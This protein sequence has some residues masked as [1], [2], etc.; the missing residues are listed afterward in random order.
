VKISRATRGRLRRTTV[1]LALIATLAPAVSARADTTYPFQNP[2]LSL[3]ARVDDLLGRLT[4]DEKISLLH[5]YEPA[6]PRL[7]IKAF[8]AGT[9]A[10]HGYAWTSDAAGN[11]IYANG[12]VF[13]QAVGLASTWDPA[14]IKQVGNVVGTEARA[15]NST[16]DANQLWGLNVWAPVVNLLRDPRWGR[17]EEGY[18]EDPALTTAI[19]SAYGKGLE[20]DN[21]KYLLTA[22]TL[23]HYLAYNNEV[24]RGTSD[25]QVTD[26][27]LKDYDQKPFQGTLSNEAATG[28]MSSYNRVNGRPD[29]VNP[30]LG[31]L[32]RSWSKNP[33]F[34]V[35]DA[36]SAQ[37]LAD[38]GD[39]AT[40]YNHYYNGYTEGDAA[41]IKAGI[42]SFTQ[43]NG[44][45]SKTTIPAI[46]DALAKGLLTTGDIDKAVKDVLALRI[47]LGEFDPDGGPYAKID[48][49]AINTTAS[50]ALNRKTAAE[51][52]VL[53]K[54]QG[55]Q[56]P[57]AKSTKSVAVV[58]PL[59]NVLYQD[60]YSG[61][62]PYSVTPVDG[63]KN[64]LGA[65]ASVTST[66]GE[67]RIALKDV[68][69]GKYV[70]AG[71][72]DAGAALAESDAASS[73]A[74]AQFDTTEWS[75]A[76][77]STL[78]SVANGK[79]VG[80]NWSNFVNDQARPNGW[81]VQQQFKLEQR[82]DGNF[83]IKYVGYETNESWW[84]NGDYLT[85]GSDGKL[86]LGAKTAD[87][88]TEFSKDVISSGADQ[89]AKAVKGVDQ[90]VVVVGSN[91]W[92]DGR[93]NHDRSTINIAPS[94]EKLIEAALKANPHTTVV[95]EDSYP[96]QI[97]WA[98]KHV[99]SILWTT[100][101]GPETGN[102]LAD[103][104]FGDTNPSGRLTQTW[105]KSDSQLPSILNY[106]IVNAKRTYLYFQ[107][108][109]LY[110]FGHGLSYSTFKYGGLR[111]GQPRGGVVPVSVDVTNT[112]KVA[113]DEVVQ[114]YTHQRTS[115]DPEPVKQL[116]T[117]Q[118]VRLA[119]GET[120]T[121]RLDIKE[122]DLA[123]WDVTRSKEVVETAKYD[124]M[125]GSSS[126]DIKARST[127]AVR[128]ETIPARS[129]SAATRAETFDGY[130][131]VKLVDESKVSGTSV[132]G[133]DGT[134]VSFKD[135]DLGSG[136]TTFTAQTAATAA[137]SIEIRA[138]SP[139]GKLLG[140]ASV[141]STGDVYTYNTSTATLTGAS[142]G[143]QTIYLVFKG[144]VRVS[145][146]S[147]K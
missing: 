87:G 17:N 42:D 107:G 3:Q 46:K 23:K 145:T 123:H 83:V 106:D 102:A 1:A 30:D 143:H 139:T 65:G 55:K 118:K 91:P 60:W 129:L 63:I 45:A 58:G 121:V 131:G 19:A 82:P 10:L 115:R 2:K 74:T 4:L 78:R 56:L 133:T 8:K 138:G 97:N 101:A 11:Q 116:Q 124:F 16:N 25:S 12:T 132:E 27:V 13:P 122:S 89:V 9:E 134:W 18:S 35:T 64:K 100:H 33:L 86:G 75:G 44:D 93:E 105:Y 53:L 61:S 95:L 24:S 49:S 136:A 114:L 39:D 110:A 84:G 22:P 127:L 20:G 73:D 70:T 68:K 76:G 28:V 140:T 47:R 69:T 34:N 130:H 99:P 15:Y 41:I 113:G 72:G 50:Q 26:R 67:D 146:F 103:V 147:L 54:N 21:S 62:F 128:G 5:Q 104:L 125:A 96:T 109:P 92:I 144:D 135:V 71:T 14:L 6:I 126:D 108:D 37:S 32:V 40:W 7:G 66:E 51:A 141:A 88:A 142:G 120:R 59:S 31:G 117:F 94:Q 137:G 119:P 36:G 90:A 77:V 29:V 112:S 85:V 43:D 57:L 81:F 38:A 111:V 79:Y 48:K 52:A 98:Q 80:Y